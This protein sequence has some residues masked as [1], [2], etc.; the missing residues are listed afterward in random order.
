MSDA[1]DLLT[2]INDYPFD[3]ATNPGGLAN[4][5]YLQEVGGLSLVARVVRAMGSATFEVGEISYSFATA[6]ADAAAVTAALTA[7]VS[8]RNDTADQATAASDA[9]SA[10]AASA[11]SAQA[12][13]PEPLVWLYF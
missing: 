8:D 4:S 5:G 9:A 1:T 13:V 2:S 6:E 3:A 12:A 10:A 11:S 7:A